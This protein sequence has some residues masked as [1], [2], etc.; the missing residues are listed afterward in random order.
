LVSWNGLTDSF[1]MKID[2]NPN[3]NKHLKFSRWCW[4]RGN[5]APPSLLGDEQ[6]L[7]TVTMVSGSTV[8]VSAHG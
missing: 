1:E 8:T 3:E 7:L 2:S 4:K 5:L 6:I